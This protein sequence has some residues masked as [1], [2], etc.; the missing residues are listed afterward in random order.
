MRAVGDKVSLFNEPLPLTSGETARTNKPSYS[1]S[2]RLDLRF[3]E[4]ARLNG[5]QGVIVLHVPA[6][7]VRH[8]GWYGHREGQSEGEG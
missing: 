3:R 5:R 8:C 2:Q 1:H 4:G 6:A 7:Q